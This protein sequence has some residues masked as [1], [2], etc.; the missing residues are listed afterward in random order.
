M[1]QNTN[2][3]CNKIGKLIKDLFYNEENFEKAYNIGKIY[4]NLM[5]QNFCGLYQDN[6]IES[7]LI[8]KY[9]KNNSI[10]KLNKI[11]IDKELHVIS[12][13]LATGGHTRLLEKIISKSGSSDILIINKINYNKI[14]LSLNVSGRHKIIYKKNTEFSIKEIVNIMSRYGKLFLYINPD[15][16]KTSISVGIIKKC[17]HDI[18]V[19]FINH[20]D[21]CFSFG[22][23]KPDIVAEIS[24]YGKILSNKKRKVNSRFIGLPISNNVVKEIP[25]IRQKNEYLI[26]S[27]AS[28]YKFSPTE[29]Y[30]FQNM[31]D[32]LLTRYDNIKIII[33]GPDIHKYKYWENTIK[34][35][36]NRIKVIK[37]VSYKEY[38]KIMNSIDLYIDS[39]PIT[40]GTTLPEI[41]FKGIPVTGILSPS[42]GYTP[43][44][45]TRFRT[46]DELIFQIGELLKNR[47]DII[48]NNNDETIIRNANEI[49][50]IQKVR[51]KI[52]SIIK[53]KNEN[54][55]YIKMIKHDEYDIEFYERIW[56]KNKKIILSNE[57]LVYIIKSINKNYIKNIFEIIKIMGIKRI[58]K[59]IIIDYKKAKN[60]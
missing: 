48:K 31:I 36:K 20:A 59:A 16:L 51:D 58:I 17:Y 60:V 43:F 22:L 6:D 40:G 2:K 55:K 56:R 24:I 26:V 46:S 8:D 18:K 32:E 41:R 9:M 49:H 27:A 19:I 33:L 44:D 15:D 25:K 50:N 42:K 47:G 5:W 28:G 34:K 29:D 23:Y 13:P 45:A 52:D 30:S 1:I 12:E 38:K 14:N 21:H 54:N 4:G 3:N 35:N 37:K 10:Y 7:L 53:T 39:L 11:Q 57:N